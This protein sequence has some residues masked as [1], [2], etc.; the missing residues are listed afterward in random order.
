M[1]DTI[2]LITFP[3]HSDVVGKYVTIA[4]TS[5]RHFRQ[6]LMDDSSSLLWK[7]G[8]K[9]LQSLQ[10]L[11]LHQ[12]RC[13]KV[14]RKSNNKF[15]KLSWI[16]GHVLDISNRKSQKLLKFLQGSIEPLVW[17]TMF[18]TNL[19]EEHNL[20]SLWG[21]LRTENCMGWDEI[22]WLET[23]CSD[24]TKNYLWDK[25]MKSPF[26][27]RMLNTRIACVNLQQK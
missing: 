25:P 4:L 12:W 16:V 23:W 3:Y 2:K 1:A 8:K 24:R 7:K 19:G 17:A 15:Y 21:A 26:S 27:K 5:T 11:M 14:L 22:R 13:H 9:W 6:E 20:H 10:K 18:W